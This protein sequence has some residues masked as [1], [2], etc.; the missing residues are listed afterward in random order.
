M[1]EQISEHDKNREEY[2]F[3]CEM[4]RHYSNNRFAVLTVFLGLSIA[5]AALSFGHQLSTAPP[6]WLQLA[7]RIGGL[8][9]ALIFG[10]FEFRTNKYIDH[11]QCRLKDLENKLGYK[12]WSTL[13]SAAHGTA[14][15][16]LSLYLIVG[17]FW[18]VALVMLR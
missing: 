1:T 12:Q 9:I 5:M 17:V 18:I 10:M 7:G 11:F 8:L 14:A 6:V 3:A 16:V 2:A 13:P 4:A 15:A